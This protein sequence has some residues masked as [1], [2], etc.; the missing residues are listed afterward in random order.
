MQYTN[1]LGRKAIHLGSS[2]FP[3]VY[4]FLS[5]DVMLGI[6]GGLVLLALA[7]ESLR[8]SLST[9]R[10][11]FQRWL[12]H[13]FRDFEHSTLVGAT[14]VALGCFLSV[15][16][17]PRLT[18]VTVMLFLSVSDALASLVGMKFGR[19]RFL[20]KSLAGSAAFFASALVLAL[21]VLRHAPLAAAVGAAVATIV[22]ALPLRIGRFKLDDNLVI[23]L[24]SGLAIS[25]VQASPLLSA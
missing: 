10:A 14:Y 5:R 17:F 9:A 7:L 12:G 25:A 4:L 20:D 23:P 22:E 13:L 24:A 21:L 3:L 2:I 19:A 8:H 16:L 15:L 6:L 11:F 1:E 18:A